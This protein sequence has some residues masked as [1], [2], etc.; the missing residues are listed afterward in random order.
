MNLSLTMLLS[1]IINLKLNPGARLLGLDV[2][3]KTIGVAISDKNL[4][5][6]TPINLIKRKNLNTDIE[7]MKLVIENRNVGGIILGYPINMDGS[8]GPMCQ[9]IRQFASNI[10]SSFDLPI[11]FWDERMST[12]AVKK[13]LISLDTSRKKRKKVIDKEAAAYILQGA[14]DHLSLLP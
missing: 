4:H 7:N 9:S 1:N 5:L 8:E 12:I 3:S 13:Q 11:I 2:G 6:A 14:L 10:D